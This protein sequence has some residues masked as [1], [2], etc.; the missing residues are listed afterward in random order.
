MF[1][2]CSTVASIYGHSVTHRVKVRIKIR[3]RLGRVV[4]AFPILI[5]NPNPNPNFKYLVE[6]RRGI[7]IEI[8]FLGALFQQ[9][10]E[11]AEYPEINK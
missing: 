10:L 11:A 6:Q 4:V 8:T 5:P 1:D 3:I 2:G 9:G 7:I